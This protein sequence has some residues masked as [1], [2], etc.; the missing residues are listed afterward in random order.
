LNPLLFWVGTALAHQSGLSAARVSGGN[1]ALTFAQ[2]EVALLAAG[3]DPNA[4]LGATLG[5]LRLRAD[6]VDCTLGAATA[7]TVEADGVELS[8]PLRC[9]AGAARW[10]LDFDNF[11]A[12]AP[13]HRMY[14][15][16]DGNPVGM[17]SA[18][19]QAVQFGPAASRLGIA[20]SFLW[21][22]V[23]HIAT[24]YD[25]LLFLLALLVVARSLRQMLTVVTGFT[26]AHSITL[27]LAATGVFTLSPSLVEPAIAAS[28]A[29]VGLENL[30]HPTIRRRVLLTFVLGL[31]HGFGFAG[32]LAE[33]GLPQG[34]LAVALVSFNGGVELGQAAICLLLLPLLLRMRRWPVWERRGVPALSIAVALFGIY[35]LIERT[36]LS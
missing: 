22:G 29:F 1:L 8:A 17:L 25:H 23:E 27:S 30:L 14:V 5:H 26:V 36:L 7:R 35:W 10:S 2:P 13:G 33:L 9:P 31:V 3:D 18:D 4:L 34:N 6:G 11:A 12:L 19:S 24:G 28:I 32:L 21:L 16:V 20:A 15:E